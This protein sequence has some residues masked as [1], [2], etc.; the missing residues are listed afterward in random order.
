MV[1][2]GWRFHLQ[3]RWHKVN[4]ED[5]EEE[6]GLDAGSHEVFALSLRKV[7]LCYSYSRL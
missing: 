2:N 4:D 3:V 5:E 1:G 7:S 6:K